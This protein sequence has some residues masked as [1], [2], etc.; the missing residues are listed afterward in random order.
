[1]RN[2]PTA[3]LG[4]RTPGPLGVGESLG[5]LGSALREPPGQVGHSPG[6]GRGPR[7][8]RVRNGGT[9]AA[10]PLSASRTASWSALCCCGRRGTRACPPGCCSRA[11]SVSGEGTGDTGKP[12]G[13][14]RRRRALRGTE[15]GPLQLTR[16]RLSGQTAFSSKYISG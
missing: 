3:N 8:A 5:D 13:A 16:P 11:R 6:S 12:V 9:Y 10:R 14:G 15:T 7:R 1:M 4:R 2:T